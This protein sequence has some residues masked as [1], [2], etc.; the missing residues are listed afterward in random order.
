ML[1]IY[2]Y[3]QKAKIKH[4]SL[5]YTTGHNCYFKSEC[6]TGFK[7]FI[8]KQSTGKM[9]IQRK[10]VNV[11]CDKE[12]FLS[13]LTKDRTQPIVVVYRRFSQRYSTA[14]FLMEL[15]KHDV[16]DDNWSPW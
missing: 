7:R 1:L 3:E 11:V 4:V 5:V 6:E 13:S 9:A 14:R 16:T 12:N 15:A 10:V 2:V 8:R